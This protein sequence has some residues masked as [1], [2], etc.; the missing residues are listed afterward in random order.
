MDL[1]LEGTCTDKCLDVFQ[2]AVLRSGVVHLHVKLRPADPVL[3]DFLDRER[4]PGDVERCELVAEL[5][6]AEASID[7]RAEGHIAADPGETV[8]I[9]GPHG[10]PR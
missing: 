10:S 9:G 1:G 2:R 8:K 5:V 7:E 4:V 6:K 3:C